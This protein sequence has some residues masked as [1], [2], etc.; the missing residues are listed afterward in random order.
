MNLLKYYNQLLQLR[1]SFCS[2]ISAVKIKNL[3]VIKL[4]FKTVKILLVNLSVL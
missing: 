1:K 2:L 3:T 4:K